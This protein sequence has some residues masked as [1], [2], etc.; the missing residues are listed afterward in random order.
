MANSEIIEILLNYRSCGFYWSTCRVSTGMDIGKPTFSPVIAAKQ[1]GLERRR[2]FPTTG[3]TKDFA[4]FNDFI[5]E[6]IKTLAKWRS[7][8]TI[9]EA[10]SCLRRRRIGEGQRFSEAK[11]TTK[12][13]I[14]QAVARGGMMWPCPL[15][16]FEYSCD[17]LIVS[18][19]NVFCLVGTV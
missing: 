18:M 5:F 7:C 11:K 13:K 4:D 6:L 3:L 17:F 15:Q 19:R 9:A 16:Q 2:V 1:R 14:I 10:T 8:L 12:H